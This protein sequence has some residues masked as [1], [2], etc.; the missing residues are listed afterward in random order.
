MVEFDIRG[1]PIYIPEVG[2]LNWGDE[3]TEAFGKIAA[4]INASVPTVSSQTFETVSKNIK[5][6]N[7]SFNYSL[8]VL[9][10]IVYTEGASTITKTLNYSLGTLTSVVLSGDTPSFINL[11]KTLV[12]SGPNLTS[13]IYT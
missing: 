5:G 7:S 10:S 2:D 12:Y 11:T 3:V 1:Q 8:G 6:W 13:I 4:G 9:T